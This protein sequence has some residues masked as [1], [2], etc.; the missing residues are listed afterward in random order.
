MALTE[1]LGA[2]AGQTQP[3]GHHDCDVLPPPTGASTDQQ[4]DKTTDMPFVANAP[5][6]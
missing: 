6:Y 1:G 5:I 2:A 4:S 3:L